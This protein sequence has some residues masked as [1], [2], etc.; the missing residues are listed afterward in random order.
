MSF[1]TFLGVTEEEEIYI[2][3]PTVV[4]KLKILYTTNSDEQTS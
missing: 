4:I 3:I 2:Y 1:E